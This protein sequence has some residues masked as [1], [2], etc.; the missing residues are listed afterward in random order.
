MK[1]IPKIKCRLHIFIRQLKNPIDMFDTIFRDKKKARFFYILVIFYAGVG[2]CLDKLWPFPKFNEFMCCFLFIGTLSLRSIL[3]FSN[4]MKKITAAIANQPAARKANLT[5]NKYN[6]T[7][8]IYILGPLTVITIFGL[9]CCSMFGALQFTLTFVWM[10]ILFVFV[11]Y[12]SIIGYIQYIFLAMYI[13]NLAHSPGQYK[14]LPKSLFECIPA[15]LEWLQLLTKLSHIYRSVF[16]TLGSAY[17][18]GYSIFCWSP[19]MEANT[20]SPIFFILWAIIFLVIVLLFP[21]VSLLEYHWIKNIVRQLKDSYI[22]DLESEKNIQ[23]KSNAL[24]FLQPV[25]RL[26]QTLCATQIIDSLSYP[27]KT[28]WDTVYVCFLSVFNFITAVATIAQKIPILIDALP[29]IF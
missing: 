27:L 16:F 21:I 11:V 20:T 12:I 5:Y 17:I 13:R 1:M 4:S 29:Q 9:G 25:H 22:R 10:L 28:A 15:R 3:Y 19:D 7:S 18:V 24:G 6:I 14:N 2:I 8:Q 26:V 23:N